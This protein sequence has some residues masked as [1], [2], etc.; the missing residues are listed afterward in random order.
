MVKYS[1]LMPRRAIAARFVD[2]F[3]PIFLGY[4][5]IALLQVI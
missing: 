3:P 4:Y 5:A 1:S 2:R